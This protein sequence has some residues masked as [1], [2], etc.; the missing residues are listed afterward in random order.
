MPAWSSSVG[1]PEIC[2]SFTTFDAALTTVAT[3]D[4][5]R[6]VVTPGVLLDDLPVAVYDEFQP[7]RVFFTLVADF[8]DFHLHGYPEA[9]SGR[10]P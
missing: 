9:S 1:L 6:D 3:L 7:A 5:P 4:F 8:G 10:G 2:S